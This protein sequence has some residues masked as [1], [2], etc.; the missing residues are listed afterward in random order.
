MCTDWLYGILK[1]Q[2]SIIAGFL[3]L[4]AGWLAYSAGL[5]QAKAVDRQNEE[6]KRT[7]RRRLARSVIVAARLMDGV[8]SGIKESVDR[9]ILRVGNS[10]ADPLTIEMAVTFW[11]RIHKPDLSMVWD[12]L[13]IL[14]QE[15]ISNYMRLDRI[16][17]KK[18]QPD[19][20]DPTNVK[21]N[22]ILKELREVEAIVTSLQGFLEGVFKNV[23][24]V[25]AE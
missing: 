15:I 7:E 23:N 4:G 18:I 22:V 19:F 6:L 24:L 16:V 17:D 12:Q 2:G 10:A 25:L 14:D 1:D 8:L 9:E 5:A 20:L 13:G 11:K 21:I 3:A